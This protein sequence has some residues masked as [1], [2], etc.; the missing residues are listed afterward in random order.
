MILSTD[1]YVVIPTEQQP[2]QYQDLYT[3]LVQWADWAKGGGYDQRFNCKNSLCESW[4]PWWRKYALD[5][6]PSSRRLLERLLQQEFYECDYPFGGVSRFREDSVKGT[7]HTNVLRLAWVQQTV[8]Q[9]GRK[10]NG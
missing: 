3:F 6:E 1:P 2:H 5:K 9:L 10:I 8:S 4:W 7:M